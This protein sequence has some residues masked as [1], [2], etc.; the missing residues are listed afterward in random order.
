M[1]MRWEDGFEAMTLEQAR[2]VREMRVEQ[3]RTWS[4]IAEE[5]AEA[6]GGDWESIQYAG[7]EICLRAATLLG[8][9]GVQEPWH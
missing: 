7:R 3:G 2:W 1:S 9:D 5:C 4:W 8:E 6:W